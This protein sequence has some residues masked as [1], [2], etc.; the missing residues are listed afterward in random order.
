MYYGFDL[1]EHYEDLWHA[2]E[3]IQ[4]GK[5]GHKIAMKACDATNAAN[6]IGVRL[7]NEFFRERMYPCDQWGNLTPHAQERL[8]PV[9]NDAQNHTN[10]T[11]NDG[12]E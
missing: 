7:A 8:S 4:D 3:S 1:D 10:I 11:G 5:S 12:Q 2:L 9:G 6:E